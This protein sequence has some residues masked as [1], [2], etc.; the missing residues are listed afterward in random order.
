MNKK[1]IIIIVAAVAVFIV[2]QAFFLL[3]NDEDKLLGLVYAARNAAEKEDLA[4]SMSFVAQSYSDS[5]GNNKAM[6]AR[7]AQQVFQHY[8][9]ILIEIEEC[10]ISFQKDNNA[11]M[12]LVCSG[13]GKRT[14]EP[15]VM[16]TQ[17]VEAEFFW[18]KENNAWRI[19]EIRFTSPKDFMRLLK[20]F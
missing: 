10:D 3:E 7:I 16:D 2:A 12:R 1:T 5:D 9:A 4:R 6:L 18:Q 11:T 13:Q 19:K 8:D 20:G 14:A 15:A 17:K